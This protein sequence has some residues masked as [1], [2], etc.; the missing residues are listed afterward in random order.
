M[1]RGERCRSRLFAEWSFNYYDHSSRV[2]NA[3]FQ[4]F[5]DEGG[6]FDDTHIGCSASGT[7]E[8]MIGV[9]TDWIP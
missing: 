3:W 7:A 6:A 4:T 8:Y 1:Q 5:G 9:P 2:C